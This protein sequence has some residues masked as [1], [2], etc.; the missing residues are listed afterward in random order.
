[1]LK[2]YG[3]LISRANRSMWML[4]EIGQPYELVKTTA[5]PDDLRTAEYLRLNPNARMPTIVSE[6][7]VRRRFMTVLLQHQEDARH[8]AAA[9]AFDAESVEGDVP[10]VEVDVEERC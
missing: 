3:V 10:I 9:R 4:E 7:V 1:M 5:H 8:D 6:Q 2:L